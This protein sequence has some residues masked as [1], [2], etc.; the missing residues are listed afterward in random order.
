MSDVGFDM[1]SAICTLGIGTVPLPSSEME[2]SSQFL[3]MLLSFIFVAGNAAAREAI[4]AVGG[5]AVTEA[6]IAGAG[7][8]GGG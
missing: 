8:N 4:V 1:T 2:V 7:G 3:S 6:E 5:R